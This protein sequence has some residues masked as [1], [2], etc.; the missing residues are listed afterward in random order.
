MASEIL[1]RTECPIRCGHTSAHVK[2]K[3][4]KVGGK[5]Y[6]YIHCRGCGCQMHIK[7]EEQENYLKAIT[8]PEKLDIPPT[9]PAPE[10]NAPEVPEI[11]PEPKKITPA[12]EPKPAP[13]KPQPE[14]KKSEWVFL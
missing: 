8:R 10:K 13:E 12:P 1:G 3:T 2:R 9:P 7:N 4:D 6:P 5:A 14:K 11:K